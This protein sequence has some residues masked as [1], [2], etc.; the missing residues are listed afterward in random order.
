MWSP[1][2]PPSGKLRLKIPWKNLYGAPVVADLDGLYVLVGPAS[3]QYKPLPSPLPPLR[4]AC[5][6][7]ATKYNAKKAASEAKE[8]KDKA[9][10]KIDAAKKSAQGVLV[11]P[12]SLWAWGNVVWLSFCGCGY[13]ASEEGAE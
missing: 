1:H 9:L 5:H 7:A 6:F 13:R 11:C 10:K 12:L 8:A 4:N 2:G 3:G